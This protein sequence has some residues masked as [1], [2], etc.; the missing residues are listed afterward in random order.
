MWRVLSLVSFAISLGAAIAFD[1]DWFDRNLS[2]LQEPRLD[3]APGD[4]STATYRLTLLPTFDP[5]FSA[6]VTVE[7]DGR[8]RVFLKMGDGQAGYD[9]GRL[10]FK[11]IVAVSAANVGSLQTALSQLDFWNRPSTS[12]PTTTATPDGVE[13]IVCT[14]GTSVIVEAVV[15]GRYHFVERHCDQREQLTP[16]LDAFR[17]IAGPY[18]PSSGG[19]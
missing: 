14:D 13:M 17:R 5:P 4:A 16:V 7:R 19:Q 2:A 15:G 3:A 10:D 6:R 1:R 18:W 11:R 9:P 8:A 12:R